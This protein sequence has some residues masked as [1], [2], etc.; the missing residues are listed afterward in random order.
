MT[1]GSALLLV[2]ILLNLAVGL[3]SYSRARRL[4]KQLNEQQPKDC[5][6][7]WE[8]LAVQ[9]NEFTTTFL[10]VRCKKCSLHHTHVYAGHWKLED[11]LTTGDLEA[12]YG[13]PSPDAHLGASGKS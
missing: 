7:D 12:L 13:K 3:L 6:H 11:L 4:A 9:H 5:A 2:A 8:K 1:F 10:L